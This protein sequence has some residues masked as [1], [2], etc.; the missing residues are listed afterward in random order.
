MIAEVHPASYNRRFDART[1]VEGYSWR[2]YW[3]PELGSQDVVGT[4]AE[5]PGILLDLRSSDV[6]VNPNFSSPLSPGI[7]GWVIGWVIFVVL[8]GVVSF[9]VRFSVLR[10][11]G[12]N[13]FVA[14]EQLEAKLAQS[15]DRKASEQP[16]KTTEERLAELDDLHRRGV[17][18]DEELREARLKVI[19]D[20]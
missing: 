8:V 18:T 11:S 19:S 14:K 12:L 13:P 2:R 9:L 7:P 4:A 15:L 20:S 1:A 3:R 17:I 10:R 16:Q 5:L 6:P